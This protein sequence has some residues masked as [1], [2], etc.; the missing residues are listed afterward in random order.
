[1]NTLLR[2]LATLAALASLTLGLA[3]TTAPTAHAAARKKQSVGIVV[4][5]RHLWASDV[6]TITGR[7]NPHRS[8]VKVVIQQRQV[9]KKK[10]TTLTR[11]TTQAG[12]YY[13]ATATVKGDRDRVLRAYVARS[14]RYRADYSSSIRLWVTPRPLNYTYE[15]AIPFVTHTVDDPTLHKG[16]STVS[17][18]GVA[19][20]RRVT[21]V[22]GVVALD[23]V[24]VAPID[25]VVLN[26]T[27][28][29]APSGTIVQCEVTTGSTGGT[30]ARVRAEI[31]DPD[32]VGYTVTLWLNG[33]SKTFAPAVGDNAYSTY[34]PYATEAFDCGVTLS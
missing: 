31:S 17:V 9:G 25:Q 26:G 14:T 19:G 6:V 34:I 10:W 1:M 8:G 22:N 5:D 13:T 7:L 11:T 20:L 21:V 15:E 30:T 28:V 24:L 2:R 12:G 18:A 33:R 4:T 3:A 27:A 23:E 32:L 29:T 16:I